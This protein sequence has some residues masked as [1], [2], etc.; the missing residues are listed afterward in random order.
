MV[1]REDVWDNLMPSLAFQCDWLWGMWRLR[2]SMIQ[3][4]FLGIQQP[5]AL[6]IRP[7]HSGVTTYYFVGRGLNGRILHFKN[8]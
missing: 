2:G 7:F 1:V 4:S 8:G 3:K 6:G 5:T